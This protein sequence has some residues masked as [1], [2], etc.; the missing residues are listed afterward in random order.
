MTQC[1]LLGLNRSG[2]YY[3][4]Q[5]VDER[6][7]AIKRRIDE[8]YTAYPFYGIRRITAQGSATS[9][10]SNSS[11]NGMPAGAMFSAALSVW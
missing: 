8:I 3:Q 5:A 7:I 9:I 6:E 1:E 2:V 4:A 10:P 11:L